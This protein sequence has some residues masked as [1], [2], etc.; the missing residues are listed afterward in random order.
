MGEARG[1]HLDRSAKGEWRVTVSRYFHLVLMGVLMTVGLFAVSAT[2]VAAGALEALFVPKAELWDTWT[3]HDPGAM[4]RIDHADWDRFLGNY[5]VNAGD[6][7]NRVAYGQV[8]DQDREA[9]SAYLD[10]L[11]TTPI[12]RYGRAEQ[13]AYWI[14]FYN[15]LTVKVVL[16]HYPVAS[17]LDIDI[18]PGIFADGP[19]DRKLVTVEG[20]E[21]SLNDIEH[22][23]L[24][25][26]WRDPRIH[27]AVN[28]ASIGCPNLA[29]QAFTG[30]NLEESLEAAAVGFVNHPRAVRV[31]GGGLTVS[32]IYSWFQTDFG[33]GEEGV[34][35][36]LKRYASADLV[37]V[38]GSVNSIDD[39]DYDWSLNDLGSNKPLGSTD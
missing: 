2:P 36:H 10:T 5:V 24:R 4:E 17:I 8:R 1:H 6:G 7:I 9:L 13:L 22:R 34:I 19:W 28:C 32:S 30:E 20:E 39:D 3:K 14:N 12:S 29:K 25:P 37:A 21:L 27:Y 26:I 23:I 33:D 18:S 35:A 31:D 11:A 16:D 38:L 15:A